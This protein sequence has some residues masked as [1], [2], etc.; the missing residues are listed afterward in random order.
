MTPRPTKPITAVTASV[1]SD[2]A[3]TYPNS[4]EGTSLGLEEAS[5][6]SLCTAKLD[7]RM[8]SS[9]FADANHS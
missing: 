4:R 9:K 1:S 3:L 6:S 7:K 5:E 8:L 2:S